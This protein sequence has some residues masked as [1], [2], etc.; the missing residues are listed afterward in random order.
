MLAVLECALGMKKRETFRLSDEADRQTYTYALA[1]R[2]LFEFEDGTIK[3][4]ENVC[5]WS[6]NNAN[7]GPFFCDSIGKGWQWSGLR[8]I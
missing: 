7:Y 8:M 1:E 3:T 5:Y 6:N 2:Y 4:S